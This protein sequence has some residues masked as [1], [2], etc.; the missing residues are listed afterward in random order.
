MVEFTLSLAIAEIGRRMRERLRGS[1]HSDI[2]AVVWQ[3]NGHRVLIDT[4]SLEVRA[5]DGWLLCALKLVTDETGVEPLQVVFY[6]GSR[7]EGDGPQ[8]SVTINAASTGAA[9]IADRWGAD[10]QRVLWDAVLDGVEAAVDRVAAQAGPQPVIL[11]G[12]H[13]TPEAL[14]VNVAAGDN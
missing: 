1:S 11:A 9:Q 7:T 6:L 10:L 4:G 14:V 2:P 12:F 8:G 13:C 5:L 3:Q